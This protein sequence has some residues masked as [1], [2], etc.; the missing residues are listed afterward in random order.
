MPSNKFYRDSLYRG[1]DWHIDLAEEV[2]GVEKSFIGATI[3]GGVREGFSSSV[4]EF[5]F[6]LLD[7]FNVRA[8]L[9]QNQ[10]A[11]LEAG[12]YNMGVRVKYSDD[13]DVILI[14]GILTVKET[15]F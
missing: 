9:D 10:T 14:H 6:E 7:S 8:S 12:D 15:L 2:N 3:S 4:T 13:D 11:P 5:N 1:E